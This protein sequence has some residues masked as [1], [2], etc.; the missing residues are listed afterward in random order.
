MHSL[1]TPHPTMSDEAL[2]AKEGQLN[3][4]V[5]LREMELKKLKKELAEV[6]NFISINIWRYGI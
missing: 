6:R 1:L 4:Q 5:I 3:V 2:R